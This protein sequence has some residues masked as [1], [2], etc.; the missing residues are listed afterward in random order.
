MYA[1]DINTPKSEHFA[2]INNYF[3]DSFKISQQTAF[4]AL[5]VCKVILSYLDQETVSMFLSTKFDT[6][7]DNLMNNWK[8]THYFD[9]VASYYQLFKDSFQILPDLFMKL[10]SPGQNLLTFNHILKNIKNNGKIKNRDIFLE[11]LKVI[12]S[13]IAELNNDYAIR[14]IQV[15][16]D[17]IDVVFKESRLFYVIDKLADVI[18]EQSAILFI[19]KLLENSE[20]IVNKMKVVSTLNTMTKI[21]QK[22]SSFKEDIDL[23]NLTPRYLVFFNANK[24]QIPIVID[25]AKLLAEKCHLLGNAL[26]DHIFEFATIPENRF[27]NISKWGLLATALGICYDPDR[28]KLIANH[29]IQISKSENIDTLFKDE[30]VIDCICKLKDFVNNDEDWPDRLIS[31]IMS[32]SSVLDYTDF[33]SAVINI[34]SKEKLEHF[35]ENIAYNMNPKEIFQFMNCISLLMILK[36][37]TNFDMKSFVDKHKDIFMNEWP[38][39]AE[40]YRFHFVDI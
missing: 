27:L 20:E 4:Y 28:A 40:K 5:D 32:S 31:L 39:N 11:S 6:I 16:K 29:I 26:F 2:W 34:M 25:F 18:D 19:K 36:S 33:I 37:D 13:S 22:I 17:V 24:D 9:F 10:I 8:F 1:A 23:L 15:L 12:L 30:A 3:D 21:V 38:P 14:I 7:V 35:A